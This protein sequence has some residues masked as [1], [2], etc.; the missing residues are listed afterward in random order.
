[1]LSLRSATPT[2]KSRSTG[3]NLSVVRSESRAQC[4][5]RDG[6]TRRVSFLRPGR[7]QLR[8]ESLRIRPTSSGSG[9]LAALFLR[10]GYDFLHGHFQRSPS[11][12]IRV[13]MR[14]DRLAVLRPG[15]AEEICGQRDVPVDSTCGERAFRELARRCEQ[16][17][18]P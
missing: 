11:F 15:A 2:I 7:S 16:D 18:V 6:M 10:R 1:M 9:L 4:K 13:P 14:L 5:S 17:R 12:E 8:S 3:S